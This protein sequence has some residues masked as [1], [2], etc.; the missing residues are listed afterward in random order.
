MIFFGLYVK[1]ENKT[2]SF[3]WL[4]QSLVAAVPEEATSLGSH[5][6]PPTALPKSGVAG[7]KHKGL[8]CAQ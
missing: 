7:K 8:Y 3:E 5:L 1:G 6:N 4:R 2:S